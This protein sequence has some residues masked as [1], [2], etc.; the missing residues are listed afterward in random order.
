MARQSKFD[1]FQIPQPRGTFR[2]SGEFTGDP[3]GDAFLGYASQTDI[4]NITDIKNTTWYY[5]VFAQ[6][7][8]R[9]TTV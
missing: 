3:L 9:V 5:A 1:L 6:D 7:D 4:Q 8:W 2:F